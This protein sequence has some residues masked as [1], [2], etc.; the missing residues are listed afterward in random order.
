MAEKPRGRD[1]YL[2]PEVDARKLSEIATG[3]SF[4]GECWQRSIDAVVVEIGGIG[5]P[6]D[7]FVVALIG[8]LEGLGSNMSVKR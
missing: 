6:D 5:Q 1:R 3:G 7:H 2:S 4:Q 8:M